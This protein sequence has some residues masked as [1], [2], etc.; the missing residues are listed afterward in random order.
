MKS[1]A[2]IIYF[3]I[4]TYYGH[5]G[6]V[7]YTFKRV[8]G[9]IILSCVLLSVSITSPGIAV[10]LSEVFSET[11]VPIFEEEPF[12]IEPPRFKKDFLATDST[13]SEDPKLI[14]KTQV[15]AGLVVASTVIILVL[16]GIWIDAGP[17]TGPIIF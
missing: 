13:P 9:I 16:I 6:F 10:F 4:L 11:V 5:L 14:T 12:V 15:R 1:L 3:T 17:I 7:R 8:S 2:L